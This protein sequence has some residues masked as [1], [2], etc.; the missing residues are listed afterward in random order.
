M[1]H[2]LYQIKYFPN[3]SSFICDLVGSKQ[4]AIVQHVRWKTCYTGAGS[5]QEFWEREIELNCN[6]GANDAM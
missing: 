1:L 5:L 6:H 4:T 3:Q 2:P